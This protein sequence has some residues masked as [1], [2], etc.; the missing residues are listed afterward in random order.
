MPELAVVTAD[1]I[2]WLEEHE[3][4]LAAIVTSLPDAAEL[5]ALKNGAQDMGEW[6]WWFGDAAELCLRA[7]APGGT[8]VF[9]QTDRRSDGVQHSKFALLHDAAREAEVPLRWHKIVLRHAPDVVDLRRPGYAHLVCFGKNYGGV[10]PDVIPHS[11]SLYRDGMPLHATRLA[12]EATRPGAVV[13][14]PFCGRG[15]VLAMAAALGREAVGLE[16]DATTAE[17]ARRCVVQ[18]PA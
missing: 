18:L 9:Y 8:A 7:L 3:G 11:S 17:L 10:T 2:P 12:I 5:A 13:H 1:A 15:T 6:A 16:I 14:D 4:K